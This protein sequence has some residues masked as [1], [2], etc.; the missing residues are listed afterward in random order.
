[1]DFISKNFLGK[2][3]IDK[4]DFR[5]YFNIYQQLGLAWEF[6][7]LQCKHWDGYKKIRTTKEV[8]R[9]CGKVKGIGELYYLIPQKG[10]KKIGKKLKP[11]SKKVFNNAQRAKILNDAIDFHGAKLNV[12]VTNSYK[13]KLWKGQSKINIAADRIVTLKERRIE[14]HIDQ[15]LVS[16]KLSDNLKRRGKEEYG[17]FPWEISKKKLRNFPVI[18]DFDENY[19][20]LGLS[21]LT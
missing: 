8:C 15:H 9:I 19:Q 16:I 11:N 3:G 1:M 20:L 21:I 10:I 14:Y 17:G 6:L 12:V 13:S 5:N 4:K 18:F 7:G 2:E